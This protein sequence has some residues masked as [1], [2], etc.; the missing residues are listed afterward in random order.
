MSPKKQPTTDQS[1]RSPLNPVQRSQ[2]AKM[3]CQKVLGP[4][5]KRSMG[6]LQLLAGHLGERHGGTTPMEMDAAIM[7]GL[8]VPPYCS[9]QT[10][11]RLMQ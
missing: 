3:G 7:R 4:G 8:T 1:S 5:L 9:C 2:Y 11:S 6:V 10:P